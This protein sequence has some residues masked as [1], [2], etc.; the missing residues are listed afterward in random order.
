LGRQLD[1]LALEPY[2]G[3]V[4]RNMLQT[5]V[6]C[7]RHRWTVLTLPPRRMERRL[8]A[9]AH[10]FAEQLS[11]QWV[12][13]TDVL[14][15]SDGLNL[16]DLHRLHPA[17]AHQPTVVYF[18]RNQLPDPKQAS[19]DPT[20]DLANLASATAASEIWFNSKYHARSFL[21]KLQLLIETHAELRNANLFEDLKAKL[22]L[23]P[24]PIDM[25]A[26]QE[27]A[28]VSQIDR[29]PDAVFIET[30]N[31]DIGLLNE[32]LNI[33]HGKLKLN[34][35]TVGPAAGLTADFPRT[36]FAEHDLPGQLRGLLAATAF[37]SAQIA[38]PFDEFAVR[39]M[40][41]S[42]H[43]VLPNTGVYPEMIPMQ[44]QESCLYNPTPQSL[45]HQLRE[46]V[47]LP[48]HYSVDELT[49]QLPNYDAMTACKLIDDRLDAVALD[50]PTGRPLV[51]RKSRPAQTM[52]PVPKA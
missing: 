48:A 11:R 8:A 19:L 39:A 35:L 45:A 1:I 36:I 32:A 12:G 46:A 28:R 9:S 27:I 43:P 42:C 30:R 4:R 3:G 2:F 6:R 18:H 24:P 33:L 49:A 14:F 20:Q 13:H 16:T 17:I 10:W 40:A 26:A 52:R 51:P 50:Q 34:L 5:L 23:V 31:A 15:T 44:L 7:S 29:D 21:D 37:L 25:L 22:R 38:S 41:M 47:Y